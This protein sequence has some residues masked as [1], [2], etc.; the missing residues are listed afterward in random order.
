MNLLEMVALFAGVFL[1]SFCI[2]YT[3]TSIGLRR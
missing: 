2:G 3:V 1:V